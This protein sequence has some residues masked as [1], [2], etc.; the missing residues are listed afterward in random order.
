M[1]L[2][3]H[4]TS[5]E[6][7]KHN[8]VPGDAG[9][10]KGVF[11]SFG[12]GNFFADGKISLFTVTGTYDW[13]KP[14]SEATESLFEFWTLDQ[15]KWKKKENVFID[16]FVGSIH[17]RKSLVADFNGDSIP[18][19]FVANHGYD[20]PPFP[21]ER[22]NIVLSQGSGKFLVRHASPE[23]DF[24]HG[25]S[26]VDLD[27]DG[28]IDVAAVTGGTGL[29]TIYTFLN[30]GSGNFTKGDNNLFSIPLPSTLYYTIE[31]IDLNNDGAPDLFL[32]G[33]EDDGAATLLFLNPGNF[34]FSRVSP[35]VI[36][37]VPGEG[38]VLDFLATNTIDGKDIWVLRTSV[39]E[40]AFY[41]STVL[42]KFSLPSLSSEIVFDEHDGAWIPWIFAH[43]KNGQTFITSQGPG[44]EKNNYQME[45]DKLLYQFE[46][47]NSISTV[48]GYGIDLFTGGDGADTIVGNSGNNIITGGGGADVLTGMGGVNTFK[49][50]LKDTLL[51]GFDH[52]TDFVIGT[53]VIDAPLPV[54]KESLKQLG[55][56]RSLDQ[57]G[58]SKIL[59]KKIFTANGAATFTYGSGGAVRTFLALNDNKS[60]FSR[61]ND[62]IIEIT[63]FS[64]NLTDLS[65]F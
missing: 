45:S 59:S 65:V 63:G 10:P 26:A 46:S 30:D 15:N 55:A 64:G 48:G 20:K 28:D 21:G 47:Y 34:D 4:K 31:F 9:F 52:I 49:V 37:A 17:G 29:Q 22:N 19:I 8:V 44:S 60:G 12:Y 57:R 50:T 11:S 13:N 14:F 61:A 38:G 18:D 1:S 25:A 53:D 16:D 32:G 33:N 51:S 24:F 54:G 35:I 41:Q 36:P 39:G 62:A 3:V 42:Q 7:A 58:I 43:S 2:L 27:L 23:V 56:V 5:Y 40:G 6:N